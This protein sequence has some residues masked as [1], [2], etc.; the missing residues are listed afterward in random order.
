[1]PLQWSSEGHYSVCH[2][3]KSECHK[4]STLVT[5]P[6]SL[7]GN[8]VYLPVSFSCKVS[9][10]LLITLL[11]IKHA[12]C[13]HMRRGLWS[14]WISR[15]SWTFWRHQLQSSASIVMAEDKPLHSDVL[16]TSVNYSIVWIGS[17][18]IIV[19]TY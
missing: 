4:E 12:L 2:K 15:T 18:T 13:S 10:V 3:D 9:I 5:P 11:S 19:N 7:H 16:L 6:L 14:L 1:M 17:K 8:V